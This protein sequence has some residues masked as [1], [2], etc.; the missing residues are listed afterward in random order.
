MRFLKLVIVFLAFAV[1]TPA[2]AELCC[3]KTCVPD[4]NRCVRIGSQDT[5]SEPGWTCGTPLP[6][7]P[8]P[9]RKKPIRYQPWNTGTSTPICGLK[10]QTG[11]QSFVSRAAEINDATNQ[12]LNQLTGNAILIACFGI[13]ESPHNVAEDKRTGLTCGQRQ[14]LLAQQCRKRCADYALFTTTHWCWPGFFD[15]SGWQSVFGDI[16]GNVIGAAN[17]E[18]CGPRLKGNKPQARRTP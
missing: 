17:V 6:P 14:T 13:F 2:F 12:C 1:I 7:P 18:L 8:G 3:V 16:G 11:T 4:G 5:C 15:N 9:G 10:N